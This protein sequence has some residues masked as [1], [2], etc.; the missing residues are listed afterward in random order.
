MPGT[1]LSPNSKGSSDFLP[2]TAAL[3]HSAGS[4]APRM[5]LSL[6]HFLFMFRPA[7]TSFLSQ[8][9]LERKF[10]LETFQHSILKN[11]FTFY[12]HLRLGLAGTK[13]HTGNG[14]GSSSEAFLHCPWS[15]S[16]LLQ[17]PRGVDTWSW[18]VVCFLALWKSLGSSWG[19][20]H[21]LG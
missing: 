9:E 1:D 16:G 21:P 19:L 15:A 14:L 17:R 18:C 12:P 11:V 10:F 4:W 3:C 20:L 8:S 13:F 7:S 5:L 6:A 2:L